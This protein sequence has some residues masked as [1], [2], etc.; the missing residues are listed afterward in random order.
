[1]L[2]AVDRL[3]NMDRAN[4]VKDN[5]SDAESVSVNLRQSWRDSETRLIAGIRM[6]VNVVQDEPN[7]PPN[8]P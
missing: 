2:L 1:L 4:G 3:G 5:A 7:V 8:Y 6:Y